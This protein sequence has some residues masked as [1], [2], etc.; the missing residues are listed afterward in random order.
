MKKPSTLSN[1]P[2]WS[3]EERRRTASRPRRHLNTPTRPPDRQTT[4]DTEDRK[5]GERLGRTSDD[6]A[7]EL[8][9]REFAE[10]RNELASY[11]RRR[12]SVTRP[13][14][15]E[16]LLQN[17]ALVAL[18]KN[19][20]P[21]L[22]TLADA[23]KYARGIIR[24][25]ARARRRRSEHLPGALSDAPG[26]DPSPEEELTAKELAERLV[27]QAPT[28]CALLADYAVRDPSE[29]VSTSSR[30][31]AFHAR[32]TISRVMS[33]LGFSDPRVGA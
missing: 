10:R 23:R 11:A 3:V 30:S 5:K 18:T 1:W 12:C 24:Q 7:R 13:N 19:E 16:D 17:A 26:R 2:I 25:L 8:L 14:E 28:E 27:A 33:P 22:R 15:V 31:R 20:I 21:M 4:K 32:N 6:S 9:L 29:P